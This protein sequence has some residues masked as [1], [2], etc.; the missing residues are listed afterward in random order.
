[1]KEL[2][3]TCPMGVPM[4]CDII[5][6]TPA[7]TVAIYLPFEVQDIDEISTV[8]RTIIA[9]WNLSPNNIRWERRDGVA[10]LGPK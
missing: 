9:S 2:T 7:D 1:M 8:V 6:A 3:F 4:P 5:G 10:Q